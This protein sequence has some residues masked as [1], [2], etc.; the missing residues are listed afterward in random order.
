[1]RLAVKDYTEEAPSAKVLSDANYMTMKDAVK[2]ELKAVV[3]KDNVTGN[4][5]DIRDSMRA[6]YLVAQL[7]AS[8]KHATGD[9]FNRAF[10]EVIDE[11]VAI[12]YQYKDSFVPVVG[13][14]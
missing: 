6:D 4:L 9:D 12:G 13:D 10:D 11:L 1:M 3:D 14:K 8:S 5:D 2:A 7:Y